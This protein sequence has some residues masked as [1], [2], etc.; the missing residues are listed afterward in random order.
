MN[1]SFTT[2]EKVLLVL[3][4]IILIGVVYSKFVYTPTSEAILAAQTARDDCDADFLVQVAKASKLRDMRRELELIVE[5]AGSVSEIPP[6]DN[7]QNVMAELNTIL[8]AAT[9]PNIDFDSVTFSEGLA[10]RKISM[11]FTCANYAQAKQVISALAGC[12]YRCQIDDLSATPQAAKSLKPDVATQ[13]LSIRLSVEFY[14]SIDVTDD[15]SEET[16]AA[17]S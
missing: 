12:R 6:Y 4:A 15:A 9:E 13:T 8:L 3:L 2:R 5:N 16:T 11:T 14:E 1:R 7:L 17:K 10:T